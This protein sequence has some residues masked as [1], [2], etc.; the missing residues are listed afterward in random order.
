MYYRQFKRAAK[1]HIN[2]LMASRPCWCTA[3]NI[4]KSM[5]N[6][7]ASWLPRGCFRLWWMRTS[8]GVVK[9]SA[10]TSTLE[11]LSCKLRRRFT[12]IIECFRQS[13]QKTSSCITNVMVNQ[14]DLLSKINVTSL[15]ATTTWR[16]LCSGRSND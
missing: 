2:N 6:H 7:R 5:Q 16:Y 8:I 13:V 12:F 11:S 14:A 1:N 4:I 9:P 3:I 10:T 15:I